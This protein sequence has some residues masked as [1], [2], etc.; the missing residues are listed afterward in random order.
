MALGREF[1][2]DEARA[3]RLIRWTRPIRVA[4]MGPRPDIWGAALERHMRRLDVIPDA[5]RPARQLV[6]R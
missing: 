4:G 3:G 5:L 1:F 2:E 6:G